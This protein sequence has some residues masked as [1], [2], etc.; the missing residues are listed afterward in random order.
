MTDPELVVLPA[1]T[2]VAGFA[3]VRSWRHWRE[4]AA[5]RHWLLACELTG[6]AVGYIAAVGIGAALWLIPGLTPKSLGDHLM[7]FPGPGIIFGGIGGH[8]VG[9]VLEW[10]RR[11]STGLE[12]DY[13]EDREGNAMK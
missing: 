7:F 4:P 9:R 10:T 2:A 3:A 12:A 1:T 5:T 8:L 13:G 11:R 6:V